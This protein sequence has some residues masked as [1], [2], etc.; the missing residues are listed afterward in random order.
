MFNI[1]EMPVSSRMK[2]NTYQPNKFWCYLSKKSLVFQMRFSTFRFSAMSSETPAQVLEQ[3][4]TRTLHIKID[5]WTT[6]GAYV[7]VEAEPEGG[8]IWASQFS[9]CRPFS[10]RGLLPALAA[11][12]TVTI[13]TVV[14][15]R[16]S[17]VVLTH[18]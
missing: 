18:C 2:I 14:F 9:V 17:Y 8:Q 15:V 12:K 1:V 16:D 5:Q 4:K 10:I 7:L 6:L 3:G 13:I 11:L